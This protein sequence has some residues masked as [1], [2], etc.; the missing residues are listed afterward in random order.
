MSLSRRWTSPAAHAADSGQLSP[1]WAISALTSVTVQLP[2]RDGRRGGRLVDDDEIVVLVDHDE[3]DSFGPGSAGPLG[4]TMVTAA[5]AATR[6]LGSLSAPVHD[7]LA[8]LDRDLCGSAEI[9][10][11]AGEEG[12]E[13]EPR[14]G[15]DQEG[16]LL[17]GFAHD[18]LRRG[19]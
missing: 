3:R 19:R 16:A 11:A 17:Y 9:R 12:V 7:D 1:Q 8:A 4:T 6:R 18:T 5:P 2:G 10:G 14:S 15:L 13:A